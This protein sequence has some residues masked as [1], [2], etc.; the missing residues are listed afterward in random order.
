MATY[1]QVLD[2]LRESK[3]ISQLQ[4]WRPD[5]WWCWECEIY[6][7]RRQNRNDYQFVVYQSWPERYRHNILLIY[8]WWRLRSH[9]DDK[10]RM[11]RQLINH[12]YHSRYNKGK[13]GCLWKENCRKLS[14]RHWRHHSL[15]TN[16]RNL[17]S[18]R[19]AI[20]LAKE[21]VEQLYAS[22]FIK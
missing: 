14:G 6:L 2:L 1:R 15:Y 9:H 7:Q 4:R 21:E 12:I 11:K 17:A 5:Y 8:H 13:N 22:W 16:N 20:I 18:P 3:R 10:R 19:K